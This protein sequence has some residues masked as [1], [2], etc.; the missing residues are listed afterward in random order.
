M[1]GEEERYCISP[2]P[3]REELYNINIHYMWRMAACTWS[4]A[5]WFCSKQTFCAILQAGWGNAAAWEDP[6]NKILN[7]IRLNSTTSMISSA[8]QKHESKELRWI[9]LDKLLCNVIP[10]SHLLIILRNSQNERVQSMWCPVLNGVLSYSFAL[11]RHC[12][13]YKYMHHYN[14]SQ[15]GSGQ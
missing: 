10:L 7:I 3:R 5:G 1:F 6:A 8:H 4:F 9:L 12:L 11:I 14:P 15:H 2:L 13:P